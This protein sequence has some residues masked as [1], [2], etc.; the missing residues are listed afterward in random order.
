VSH[1]DQKSYDKAALEAPCWLGINILS[2]PHDSFTLHSTE[3]FD[4]DD[5]METP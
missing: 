3:I 4:H 5:D 2:Q 1:I